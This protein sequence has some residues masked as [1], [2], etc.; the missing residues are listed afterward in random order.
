[1]KVG[2][3]L[4]RIELDI[5]I[6]K[7]TEVSYRH[8]KYILANIFQILI[9]SDAFLP[10]LVLAVLYLNVLGMEFPQQ[11]FGRQS[12]L[13]EATISIVY[14]IGALV[15]FIAPAMFPWMVNKFGLT[16]TGSIAGICQMLAIAVAIIGLFVPDSAY[17]S[18]EEDSQGQFK[19]VF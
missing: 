4:S 6:V 14:I 19:N 8:T 10:G 15:G 7:H 13:T 16:K 3:C 18:F 9:E 2:T 17:N 5:L 11:G 12:C 1:M